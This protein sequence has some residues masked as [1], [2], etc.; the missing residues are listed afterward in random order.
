MLERSTEAAH[1]DL[2]E[3]AQS[4]LQ[5]VLNKND[6]DYGRKVASEEAYSDHECCADLLRSLRLSR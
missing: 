1:E 3:E 5:T 6:E 4:L 2:R